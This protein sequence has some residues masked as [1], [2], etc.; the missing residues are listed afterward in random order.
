VRCFVT[1]V[2]CF[3]MAEWS[4]ATSVW[5]F[6]MAVW[7]FVTAW[8]ASEISHHARSRT[9]FIGTKKRPFHVAWTHEN[10]SAT[11][12]ERDNS[13]G[14]RRSISSSIGNCSDDSL[15]GIG[16]SATDQESILRLWNL[17]LQR[18]RC[19]RQERFSN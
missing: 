9:K 4:F 6:E 1:A 7:C 5:C 3:V 17:Q 2:W 11:E 13:V 18:Q 15:W 12:S 8:W 14:S 19:S 10:P 16:N